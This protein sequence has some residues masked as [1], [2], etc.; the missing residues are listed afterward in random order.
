MKF[1]I[2]DKVQVSED[3]WSFAGRVGIIRTRN[4]TFEGWRY[5][6]DWEGEV[7]DG[8]VWSEDYLLRFYRPCGECLHCIED[9]NDYLCQV[10]RNMAGVA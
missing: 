8:G 3:H 1:E 2:G 4:K 10:C 9:S 7:S 5:R 6:V